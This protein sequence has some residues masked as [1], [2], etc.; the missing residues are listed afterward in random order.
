GCEINIEDD[1]RGLVYSRA[2]EGLEVAKEC[3]EGIT[4]EVEVGKLYRGKVVS[5]KD[6]GCFVEVLPG[7]EGLVHVS[8]L[9]DGFVDKVGDLVS[10]GDIIKVK[11]LGTDDQ[12]RIK[13]SKKGAE[14]GDGGGDSSPPAPSQKRESSHR[15]GGSGRRG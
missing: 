14:D 7:Q 10:I 1:G 13:L 15:G 2:A 12:G 8:E 11:C 3:I 9:A 4:A 6:F 5:I